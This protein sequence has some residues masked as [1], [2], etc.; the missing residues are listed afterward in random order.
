[1]RK[2]RASISISV[3]AA[4]AALF[5]I[6]CE[7]DYTLGS[8]YLPSGQ[9]MKTL[10]KEILDGVSE[11]AT[12]GDAASALFATSLSAQQDSING[13]NQSA[14]YFGLQKDSKFGTRR[15]GFFSQ[16]TPAYTLDEN[17][18]AED[19]TLALDSM[20]LYFAVSSYSGDT[21]SRQRYA[22]YEVL[23]DSFLTESA[24]SIFLVNESAEIFKQGG[25]LSAEPVLTFEFPY[26]ERGV[27]ASA[28]TSRIAMGI[29]NA[30][31]TDTGRALF[32]KLALMDDESGLDYTIYDNDMTEF[33]GEFKGFYIAP[34]NETPE[35]NNSDEGATFGATLTSS[36]FGIYLKNTVVEEVDG[37]DT[38]V[39]YDIYMTYIYYDA[40]Y[41]TD[42][43]GVSVATVE[44]GSDWVGNS[45]VEG[46][47]ATDL[48]VE[49]MGGVVTEL[50][51][52]PALFEQFDTWIA[53]VEDQTGEP[54]TFDN[55]FINKARV[56]I[57]IADDADLNA[58]PTRLGM[59]RSFSN[60]VDEDGYSCMDFV[61]D[62][63][64]T[65]ELSY[66]VTSSYSGTLNRS[67]GCYEMYLSLE[68]QEMYANYVSLKEA[69]GGDI[70][71]IDWST[72]S[73]N[74]LYVAPLATNIMEPRYAAL[75]NSIDKPIEFN[76]TYTV[77]KK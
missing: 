42:I 3:L 37:L 40:Y 49:G 57:H 53:E 5:S 70:S 76:I 34:V 8:D 15:S 18:F 64:Y 73:W 16:Y 54:G 32:N 43:G 41:I 56:R 26:Q 10:N 4:V 21:L 65:Y 72:V 20:F 58:L 6:G 50:T 25:V 75:Q 19:G 48:Y 55:I 77:M 63:N 60:L 36:G 27:Y 45:V 1:M 59:F 68:L 7:T 46:A 71:A 13:L 29:N 74:K 2:F 51:I 23:D 9:Q 67:L 24:D 44:R 31:I 52:Q 66:G 28:S 62:Y 47:A 35:N 38:E 12:R 11:G 69:A 33:V 22:L 61:N 17:G 39:N 30:D 14:G